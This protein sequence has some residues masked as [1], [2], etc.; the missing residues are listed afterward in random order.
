MIP[1]NVILDSISLLV[2][3][4]ATKLAHATLAVK[5]HLAK[6]AFV[7]AATRVIGDFTE[8]NFTGFA[9]KLAAVGAQQN[10]F[11]PITG[12]RVV[13]L[14]EPAG[15]WHWQCG[16][17][18]QLPQTIYGFYVTDNASAVVYGCALLPQTVLLSATGDAVDIGNVR[19]S[20]S[21]VTPT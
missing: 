13:Q 4:D 15:G 12:Q 3:T 16:D 21:P 7:P 19:F 10:F 5:V 2:S 1:T 6:A 18:L 20:F 11:D 8:A 14:V 9:A 17:A